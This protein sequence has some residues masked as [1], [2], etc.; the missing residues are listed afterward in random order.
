MCNSPILKIEV[1]D[2]GARNC[3]MVWITHSRWK[4]QVEGGDV[5]SSKFPS[6]KI[7]RLSNRVGLQRFQVGGKRQ[8][9]R[10]CLQNLDLHTKTQI[11]SPP[12]SHEGCQ[13]SRLAV[14][15]RL[16]V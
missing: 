9:R 7:P 11:L 13:S 1:P 16:N 14:Y 4:P 6:V 8:W 12:T 10:D 2:N 3:L 15:K 5:D